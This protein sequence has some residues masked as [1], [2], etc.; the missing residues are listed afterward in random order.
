LFEVV[1]NGAIRSSC[2]FA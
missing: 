1:Q 2:Y